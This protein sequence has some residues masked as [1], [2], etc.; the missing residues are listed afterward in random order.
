MKKIK[1]GS[2]DLE[3]S[4]VILGLMRINNAKDPVAVLTTAIENGI[5]FFDHADIYGGGEC[6]SIFADALAQTEYKR[7]DLFIQSKCGIV[8]GKMFDFSK[9]HIIKSVEGSLK[10]LKM[11]YLDALL[12]HRPDTLVEPE[13]VAAAFDELEKAGKV[14]Y[15]GVSNQ[16]PGQ[17]ELL[18]KYVSQPLL[19]NQLQFGIMHT[20]MIDRGTHVNMTDSGSVDHDGGILEYSRLNDMTIQAW[21]PYQYGFFEGVFIGNEKFPELNAKLEELAEKYQT[22][23]TGIASA[24][25][26]RHPANMQVIA[27]TMTPHRIEEIAK[28][29]TIVLTRQEWYEVYL[30]AGNI[31]P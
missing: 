10:R 11:D 22:T 27:G 16:N 18:K 1:F 8:P 4:S 28:A 30:A 12:L 5:T 3:I 15:F 23:A 21:S 29:S 14:K 20:G 26:L 19:A 6:E 9:E 13:E 7:E 24:W 17:I 31:L 25:I 2:T